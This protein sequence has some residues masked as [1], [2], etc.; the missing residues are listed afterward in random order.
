MSQ[1]VLTINSTVSRWKVHAEKSWF[2]NQISSY[3]KKI[4]FFF[5]LAEIAVHLALLNFLT[6]PLKVKL[7]RV[8]YKLVVRSI[9]NVTHLNTND[10][11]WLKQN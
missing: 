11:K 10:Y 8:Y 4:F 2:Y 5:K 7:L 1:R 6:A 9:L 3:E